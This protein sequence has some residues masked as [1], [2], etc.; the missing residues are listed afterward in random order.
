[1]TSS[2]RCRKK[3]REGEGMETWGEGSMG[4]RDIGVRDGE[5]KERR[6]GKVREGKGM[7]EE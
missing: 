2:R 1:M 4:G 6:W 7:N 5:G 3:E